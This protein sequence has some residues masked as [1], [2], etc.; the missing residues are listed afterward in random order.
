MHTS[1]HRFVIHIVE[2]LLLMQNK[3]VLWIITF[4]IKH[5]RNRLVSDISSKNYSVWS[6]KRTWPVRHQQV[7]QNRQGCTQGHSYNILQTRCSRDTKAPLNIKCLSTSRT[8][9]SS[10]PGRVVI[11]WRN[12]VYTCTDRRAQYYRAVNPPMHINNTTATYGIYFPRH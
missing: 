2:C 12:P 6:R 10:G 5:H 1:H 11:K 3:N 7:T 9:A 4:Q 8:G